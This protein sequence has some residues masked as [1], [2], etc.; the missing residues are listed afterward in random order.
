MNDIRNMTFYEIIKHAWLKCPVAEF[1]KE[2][3]IKLV[4]VWKKILIPSEGR[5]G[6]GVS[7][8]HEHPTEFTPKAQAEGKTNIHAGG[9]K[10]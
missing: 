5:Q 6:F 10:G 2:V 1:R 8:R 7:L 3:G 9:L 4:V